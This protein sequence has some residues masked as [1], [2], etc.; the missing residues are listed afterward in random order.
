M[1]KTGSFTDSDKDAPVRLCNG[2]PRATV[3]AVCALL[4]LGS[5]S[6]TDTGEQGGRP[7]KPRPEFASDVES[8]S[9]SS[10][11]TETDVDDPAVPE[12]AVFGEEELRQLEQLQTAID[13]YVEEQVRGCMAEKGFEY[14]MRSVALVKAT[15]SGSLS[16][17][18]QEELDSLGP[19]G[20][21]TYN[22]N[23]AMLA[24]L[25]DDESIQWQDANDDC[26]VS[27]SVGHPF[28]ENDTWYA[29]AQRRASDLTAADPRLVEAQA[30]ASE[31]LALAG[32]RDWSERVAVL[33]AEVQQLLQPL[34]GQAL[35]KATTVRVDE[36]ETERSE[37][38]EIYDDCNLDRLEVEGQVFAEYFQEIAEEEEL[39]A[40]EW[41]ASVREEMEKYHT[42]LVALGTAEG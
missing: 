3:L 31:C 8:T 7:D 20:W 12:A 13:L 38:F 42:Q 27:E 22:P 9:G 5:C 21:Q 39:L 25:S 4:L 29:G 37:L 10:E 34:E 35:D 14:E 19:S 36:I 16:E 6:E 11:A 32:Y 17:A 1:W 33:D 15:S 30:K 23:A 28:A 24:G 41:A 2:P 40:A 18:E 26:L